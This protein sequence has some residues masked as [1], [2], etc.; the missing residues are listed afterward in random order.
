MPPLN[1]SMGRIFYENAS[2]AAA[3]MLR[4]LTQSATQ[5]QKDEPS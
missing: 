3:L 4:H 2:G 1:F 5:S